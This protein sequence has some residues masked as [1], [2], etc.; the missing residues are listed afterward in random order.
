M[1]EPLLIARGISKSY[2]GV[3]AVDDMHVCV[4]PGE[5]VALIGPNGSG[6]STLFDC[7]TGFQKPNSGSVHFGGAD[8]SHLRPYELAR[9]GLRRTF[10]QLRVFPE[11][12]V[13]ANLLA[14]AQAANGFG[15]VA[16]FLGGTR[17]RTQSAAMR[18]RCAELLALL[19][20]EHVQE[21]SATVLSYGQKKLLELGMALMG[22]PLLLM[23]DE[24]MAGVNPTVIEDLKHL[25]LQ[26]RGAGTAVL[27]VEHNLKLIL[28]VSDRVYVMDQGRLLSEGTPEA[29]AADERVLQAYLGRARKV[30]HAID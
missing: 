7:I 13:A 6:K 18:S 21:K 12:S 8:V 27:I 3:R 22:K 15:F 28:E 2:A 17:I 14:A 19:R 24:P 29:I 11:L 25:L 10:Q 16:E 1:S 23:L 9:Q 20:L 30:E 4:N 26:V 5:L